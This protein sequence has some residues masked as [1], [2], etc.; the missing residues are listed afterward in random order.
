M[1]LKQDLSTQ[2]N[3][4]PPLLN[5]HSYDITGYSAID[6]KDHCRHY[7]FFSSPGDHRWCI[8]VAS[9]LVPGIKIILMKTDRITQHKIIRDVLISIL[10]YALPV[11]LMLLSFRITGQRPWKQPAQSVV[12]ASR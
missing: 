6:Q 12:K 1:Y 3:Y 11:L 10:L 5:D 8:V 7:H 9:A 4:S 2:R